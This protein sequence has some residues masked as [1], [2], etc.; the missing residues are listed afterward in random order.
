MNCHAARDLF[1]ALLDGALDDAER[2]AVEAHV[3]DC[4]ACRILLEDLDL[5]QRTARHLEPLT[6][7]AASWTRLAKELRL[8]SSAAEGLSRAA[9]GSEPTWRRW[10]LPLAAAA[11]LLLA[12][13]GIVT[14]R[15]PATAPTTT[16]A[17]PG[18]AAPASSAEILGSVASE[19]RLAEQHYE[20][21]IAGLEKLAGDRQQVLDP[22]IAAEL[23]KNLQLIDQ[24][25]GE[26]RAAL[27]TQPTSEQAQESLFEAFRNKVALLQDTIALINEMRKG[28][29]A[30]AAKIAE[31][32]KKS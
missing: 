2:R 27:R 6:P 11:G 18:V 7:P 1:G 24:A 20:N 8:P 19:L 15:R 3:R 16:S 25:I 9:A 21:A 29:Q 23:Q 26:S 30:E 5:V 13:A 12:A 31:G 17:T 10:A 14:L 28:N 22:Q 32:L 4:P